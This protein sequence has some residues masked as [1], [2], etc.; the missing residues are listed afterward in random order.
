MWIKIRPYVRSTYRMILS[1]RYFIY[2]YIRYIKY[3]GLKSD[4]T[5]EEVRNYNSAMVYHGLEK[6]LSYKKRNQNSGW[7]NAFQILE[8][9]N[10]AKENNNIGFHDMKSKSVL[11]DFLNLPENLND[12]RHSVIQKKLNSLDIRD[13]DSSISGAVEYSLDSYKK[14]ILKN[15]EDFFYSRYSLREFKDA[16]VSDKDIEKAIKLSMKTP[17]VCNRQAWGIYHTSESE[18][19]NIVLNYQ[20]GNK[21]FGENVPNIILIT[22]DLKAFFSADEHYQYWIDGGLL[23]MSIMYALHS[24]GIASC[25][26]N[27][28]AKPK[29]DLALRRELKIKENHTIIMVLAVGY[30]DE[31]NKVCASPRRP[32]EEVFYK[33][34]KK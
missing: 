19:K 17:S 33:L 28:S 1:L 5:D 32:M 8:L 16:I 25:A 15:P 27:W 21:P 12:E 9:L 31:T 11:E 29:N 30:P 2:D 6:S 14:G 3:S 34:E 18:I 13:N 24:L 23:S 22:T 7:R 26:L 10:I 20:H 4:M